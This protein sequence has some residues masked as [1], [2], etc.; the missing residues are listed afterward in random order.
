MRVGLALSGGGARG[1]AHFGVF[2][3]LE[4]LGVEIHEVSGTSAGAIAGAFY[5]HGYS[6]E[7]GMKHVG[8]TSLLKLIWPAFSLRGLFNISRA[9]EMFLKYFK[10][11]SF[12]SAN[13]P[14]KVIATNLNTGKSETFSEGR[15]VQALTASCCLPFIFDPVEI[16]GQLYVDGGLVNNLP[17]EA[18]K[19]T[20]DVIIGVNVVP[21][22][23]DDNL[24]GVKKMIERISMV[25]ISANVN[26]SRKHCDLLIEPHELRS[27]GTFDLKRAQGIFDIGYEA[28]HHA[29]EMNK[30]NEVIKRL[31]KN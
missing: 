3:A 24:G 14:L 1:I 25:T 21:V 9:E 20:C 22:I 30:D 19:E 23:P 31:L 16:D 26:G 6:P 10:E 4:E 27:Y 2:K 8:S 5:T 28:T 7:E 11:D 13:R 15:L 17:A 29:F 12:E 18:L